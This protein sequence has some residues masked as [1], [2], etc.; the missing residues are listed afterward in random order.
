MGGAN[1]DIAG[2]LVDV[3]NAVGVGAWNF[4]L[5]EVVPIDLGRTIFA[6][7]LLAVILVISK[8]FLFLGVDGYYRAVCLHVGGNTLVD[9][10]ELGIS[11]WV[12][13]PLDGLEVALQTVA[14]LVQKCAD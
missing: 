4:W 9:V 6:M 12:L 2:V 10:L 13:L 5:G 11:I 7:P 8:H 14:N 1:V 3:V